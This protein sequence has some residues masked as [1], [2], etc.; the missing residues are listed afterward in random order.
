[1][2]D[3]AMEVIYKGWLKKATSTEKKKKSF[4]NRQTSAWKK[5]YFVLLRRHDPEE[6]EECP[7]VSTYEKES[8]TESET[9]KA[10]L[11]LWPHYRVDKKHDE[12][13]KLFIFEVRTPQD[14][15]RLMADSEAVMDLWVFYLQ[16]QTKLRHEFPGYCFEV[17]PDESDPMRRI[18]AKGSKCLLHVSKWGLTL[19]LKRTRSVLAQWPL[20]SI[21]IFE[22]SETGAFSFE[23]GR[24]APMGEAR[25]LF[26]TNPGEDGRMYDLLDAFTTEMQEQ[27]NDGS[28]DPSQPATEEEVIKEYERLRLATFGLL[29]QR[30]ASEIARQHSERLPGAGP[31]QTQGIPI[32]ASPTRSTGPPLPP[33]QQGLKSP[34]SSFKRSYSERGHSLEKYGRSLER[35]RD[36][37]LSP[38]EDPYT[39]MNSSSPLSR[40]SRGHRSFTEADMLQLARSGESFGNILT[41]DQFR[42][43][44]RS[45]SNKGTSEYEAMALRLGHNPYQNSGMSLLPN[46]YENTPLISPSPGDGVFPGLPNMGFVSSPH[47]LEPGPLVPPRKYQPPGRTSTTAEVQA[48]FRGQHQPIRHTYFQHMINKHG[49]GARSPTSAYMSPPRHAGARKR[50]PSDLPGYSSVKDGTLGSHQYQE[51]FL[52]N[53]P[54]GTLRRSMSAD[55]LFRFRNSSVSSCTSSALSVVS[56]LI[57]ALDLSTYNAR[58]SKVPSWVSFRQLPSPPPPGTHAPDFNTY[59]G[60][61][62]APF[63]P[64][65]DFGAFATGQTPYSDIKG[66]RNSFNNNNQRQSVGSGSQAEAHMRAAPI[67]GSEGKSKE[68]MAPRDA[69]EEVGYLEPV[70]KMKRSR[71]EADILDVDG[72]EDAVTERKKPQHRSR[73]KSKGFFA[74]LRKRTNSSSNVSKEGAFSLSGGN[75]AKEKPSKSA[76]SQM[77]RSQ[78]NPDLLDDKP[79]FPSQLYKPQGYNVA[80]VKPASHSTN[81]APVTRRKKFDF[82]LKLFRQNSKPSEEEGVGS[83]GRGSDG[84]SKSQRRSSKSSLSEAKYSPTSQAQSVENA[85]ISLGVKGIVASEKA[86]SFRKASPSGPIQKQSPSPTAKPAVAS[87]PGAASHSTPMNIVAP[88]LHSPSPGETFAVLPTEK[89]ARDR[90][91]EVANRPLPSPPKS[92][93]QAPKDA[94]NRSAVRRFAP[95]M[96]RHHNGLDIE[97]GTPLKKSNRAKKSAPPPPPRDP[98]TSLDSIS[99]KSSRTNSDASDFETTAVTRHILSETGKSLSATGS[100]RRVSVD[101][102]SHQSSRPSSDGSQYENSD[103][104]SMPM[105]IGTPPGS[106]SERNSG[107]SLDAG[108]LGVS[109]SFA[110][111]DRRASF[112]HI[113]LRSSRSNSN[114]SQYEN[115]DFGSMSAEN[116]TPPTHS[117][118][119]GSLSSRNSAISVEGRRVG[120]S[121]SFSEA[122]RRSVGSVSLRSS[123]G[124]QYENTHI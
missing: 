113:S 9:P 41:G 55:R 109:P 94:S 66:N 28:I 44:L 20:K 88:R 83:D 26:A 124:S 98:N 8:V 95:G 47:S 97:Q 84:E 112:G 50:L 57:G 122:D 117:I 52:F 69:T 106:F 10:S 17:T 46:S 104:E 78:S 25:Y 102:T 11:K 77:K 48:D 40:G 96:N 4:L 92:S 23:A 36:L 14:S 30:S 76:I 80:A 87:K 22:S 99:L 62:H 68:N 19:A 114:A 61:P 67:V 90:L 105:Q 121:S 13:G 29:G 53:S 86:I 49:A 58:S 1:M 79:K 82:S 101:G 51:V 56:P 118:G 63:P 3:G 71:S 12:A 24:S 107:I 37:P 75:A 65:T 64:F 110:E 123:N 35:Q 100:E 15:L 85:P 21:R 7:F 81:L 33:R 72:S 119:S 2:A 38:G 42:H 111:V 16:I 54:R 5:G 39:T 59:C 18:G 89:A 27:R 60:S 108:R 120:K 43:L 32:R 73:S 93:M 31:T 6:G 74:T 70:F 45:N 116:G 103:F 91:K 34:P 115:T